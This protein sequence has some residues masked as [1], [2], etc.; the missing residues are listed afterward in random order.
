MQNGD[1]KAARIVGLKNF[2]KENNGF[3]H[4]YQYLIGVNSA[5]YF[6]QCTWDGTLNMIVI[7]AHQI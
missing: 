4:S 2:L 1:T 3:I 7:I 5:Q 6:V